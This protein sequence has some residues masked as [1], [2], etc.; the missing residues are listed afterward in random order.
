[1]KIFLMNSSGNFAITALCLIY[2]S[3]MACTERT[4][5]ELD[6]ARSQLDSLSELLDRER[7][8]SDSL[9]NQL[10]ELQNTY[11]DYTVYFPR[12]YRKF[13]DPESYIRKSLK[14][15]PEEI[16][17]EGVLGGTME[18]RKI[19]ILTGQWLLAI[20][21]DGHIQGKSIF[22]YELQRNDSLHFSI[23]LSE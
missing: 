12:K 6:Q 19:D 7:L 23:L 18:F 5:P 10:S 16:P 20:Y 4:D 9:E 1:M 2:F 22:R 13:E 17:M 21:D 11:K 15:K 3:L 8:I 14:N